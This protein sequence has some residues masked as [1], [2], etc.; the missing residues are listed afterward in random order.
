[1]TVKFEIENILERILMCLSKDHS[2]I[3]IELINQTYEGFSQ[4]FANNI[5]ENGL[6]AS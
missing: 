4:T 1:M 6:S 3:F 2:V 5:K